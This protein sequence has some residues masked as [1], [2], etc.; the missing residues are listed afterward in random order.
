MRIRLTSSDEEHGEKVCAVITS[1][2]GDRVT[3]KDRNWD[4]HGDNAALIEFVRE[5]SDEAQEQAGKDVN[6]DGE[7]VRLEGSKTSTCELH[8][9]TRRRNRTETYPKPTMRVGRKVVKPN[10]GTDEQNMPMA[11]M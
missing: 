10:S 8:A 4:N 2:D 9:F 11:A 3:N 5:P 7:I 6:R 1:A